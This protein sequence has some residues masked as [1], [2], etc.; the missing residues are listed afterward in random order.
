M[1]LK[2]YKD[3]VEARQDEATQVAMQIDELM[4]EDKLEDALALQPKLDE[5]EAKVQEAQHLYDS[6][7]NFSERGES[8]APKFVPVS[9]EQ[10]RQLEEPK[11]DEMVKTRSQFD[12][13]NAKARMEFVK[14][15][16]KVVPDGAQ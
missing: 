9:T 7:K 15:G 3:A 11:L 4:Q 5:A 1:D 16:G 2:L 13:L 14:T 10:D 8:A 12:A 6:M